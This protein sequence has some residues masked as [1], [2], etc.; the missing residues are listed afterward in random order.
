MRAKLEAQARSSPCGNVRFLGKQSQEQ[1][2]GIYRRAS[3]F[4]LAAGPAVRIPARPAP[5]R[6]GPAALGIPNVIIEAMASG[7]AGRRHGA[8]RRWWKLLVVE[9]EN[10]STSERDPRALA[11]ALRA[12]PPTRRAA[13]ASDAAGGARAQGLR[14]RGTS[15]EVAETRGS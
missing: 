15:A 6:L 12:S 5:R 2:P 13:Q 14:H 1:A 7:V 10:A 4:V 8:C 3:V 9:G 11:E